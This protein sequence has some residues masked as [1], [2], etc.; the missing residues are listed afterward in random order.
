M[1]IIFSKLIYKLGLISILN[2]QSKNEIQ[3]RTGDF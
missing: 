1:H 2:Y 3:V